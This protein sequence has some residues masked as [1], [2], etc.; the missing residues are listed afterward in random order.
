MNNCHVFK[1]DELYYIYWDSFQEQSLSKIN[2][3]IA[4]NFL[5]RVQ[6]HN[7]ES[8]CRNDFFSIFIY[9]FEG[10]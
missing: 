3:N 7:L 4:A 9:T 1:S 6:D 2:P 8:K 5:I 10:F